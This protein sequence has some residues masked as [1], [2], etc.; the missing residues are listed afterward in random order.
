M[1][2]NWVH[3]LQTR[4]DTVVWAAAYIEEIIYPVEFNIEYSGGIRCSSSINIFMLIT[5]SGHASTV[6]A[7]LNLW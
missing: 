7:K 1:Q 3:G 6:L 4:L 2:H 5:F